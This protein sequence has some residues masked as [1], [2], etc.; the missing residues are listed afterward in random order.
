MKVTN[1]NFYNILLLIALFNSMLCLGSLPRPNQLYGVDTYQKAVDLVY[2]Q[3]VQVPLDIFEYNSACLENSIL[4]QFFIE[5]SDRTKTTAIVS[6]LWHRIKN[7]QVV[8]RLVSCGVKVPKDILVQNDACK[9]DEELVGFFIYHGADVNA[10]D[11]N[12]NTLLHLTNDVYVV[13]RVLR[14][15]PNV[16]IKNKES[17]FCFELWKGKPHEQVLLQGYLAYRSEQRVQAKISRSY[18]CCSVQ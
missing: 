14:F 2:N 17:K 10:Q 6:P 16:H 12:G 1:R 7:T 18:G 13:N 8:T 9:N 3:G 11:K 5:H 15:N 4:A